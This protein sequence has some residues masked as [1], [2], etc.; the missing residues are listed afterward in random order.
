MWQHL[1][2]IISVFDLDITNLYKQIFS[3]LT[4]PEYWYTIYFI[5]LNIRSAMV[6]KHTYMFFTQHTYSACLVL[7]FSI[8]VVCSLHPFWALHLA[9]NSL[10]SQRCDEWHVYAIMFVIF[11]RSLCSK[12]RRKKKTKTRTESDVWDDVTSWRFLLTFKQGKSKTSVKS[13]RE[14][15]SAV[16]FSVCAALYWCPFFLHD[17]LV[18]STWPA[19]F[20]VHNS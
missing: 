4:S 12:Q 3:N 13:S 16:L 20:L 11:S 19:I 6:W 8:S 18:M 2:A 14:N 9:E 10:W 15:W 7:H 17:W 5:F 1:H